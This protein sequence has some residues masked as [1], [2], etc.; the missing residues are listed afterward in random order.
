MPAEAGKELVEFNKVYPQIKV[1]YWRGESE[2]AS[3]KLEQEFN[4]KRRTVDVASGPGE[5]NFPRWRKM[6]LFEKFTDLIPEIEKWEGDDPSK[7][8]RA[9]RHA[10]RLKKLVDNR[11]G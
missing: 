11:A 8:E 1:E 6:G 10:D 9:T 4:S 5:V 7:V 2:E 3:S